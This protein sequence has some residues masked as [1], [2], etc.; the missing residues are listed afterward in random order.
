MLNATLTH[1]MMQPLA[2][3]ISF[4][5]SLFKKM[6]DAEHKRM[7]TLIVNSAKLL[8]CQMKDLLDRS[9]LKNGQMTP[10]YELRRVIEIVQEAMDILSH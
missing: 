10:H 9:L 6:K 2:C 7:T 3:I 4:A 8:Q 5:Q 1:E